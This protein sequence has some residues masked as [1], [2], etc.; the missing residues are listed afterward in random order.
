MRHRGWWVLR[1]HERVGVGGE[2]ETV[3]RAKRLVRV[4]AQHKT[5]ASVRD[6]A[7]RELEPLNRHLA[8]PLRVTNM[9]DFVDRV[10][11]PFVKQQK[12]PSTIYAGFKRFFSHPGVSTV[13]R[14][15]LQSTLKDV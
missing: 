6:L 12:R 8:E 9:G 1:Y 14:R 4:D 10:Y 5:K 15:T 13:A 7:Q 2:I 11:L 3:Q